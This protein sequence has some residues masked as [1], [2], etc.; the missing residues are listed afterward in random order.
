MKRIDSV[1]IGVSSYSY[2]SSLLEGAHNQAPLNVIRDKV[3]CF[4]KE[5]FSP[6]YHASIKAL[7]CACASPLRTAARLPDPVGMMKQNPWHFVEKGGPTGGMVFVE[8][9]ANSAFKHMTGS[10]YGALF[11]S[12]NL[13]A[14]LDLTTRY[15]LHEL[16]SMPVAFITKSIIAADLRN[17]DSIQAT[18]NDGDKIASTFY[19]LRSRLVDAIAIQ[20]IQKK[21]CV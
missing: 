21:W 19:F 13:G 4:F 16:R 15:K 12:A 20:G 7:A 18:S 8:Q 14:V 9:F 17:F 3:T 6:F 1:H 2:F 5:F 10:F 11:L